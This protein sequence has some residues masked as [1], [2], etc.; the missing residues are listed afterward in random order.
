[1]T[2]FLTHTDYTAHRHNQS[3]VTRAAIG[4]VRAAAAGDGTISSRRDDPSASAPA[5]PPL[6]KCWIRP[7][8]CCLPWE[9]TQDVTKP[10]QR[11]SR[12]PF[13]ADTVFLRVFKP[14][15]CKTGTLDGQVVWMS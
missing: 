10:A 11:A 7:A 8:P 13:Q 1:M 14:Q 4:D 6:P 12:P 3:L 2:P 5:F 9:M 15:A